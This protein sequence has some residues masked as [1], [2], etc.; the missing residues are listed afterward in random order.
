VLIRNISTCPCEAYRSASKNSAK[1]TG[2]MS[3]SNR[4][5]CWCRAM[6]NPRKNTPPSNT[7]ASAIRES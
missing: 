7:Y 1:T 5:N 6:T 4:A 2:S 3:P